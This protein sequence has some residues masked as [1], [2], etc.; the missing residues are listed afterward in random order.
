LLYIFA[1]NEKSSKISGLEVCVISAIRTI[2]E[3]TTNTVLYQNTSV[4]MN[5]FMSWKS[6][7]SSL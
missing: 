2:Q 7:S 6:F 4:L 5:K 1:L 3:W